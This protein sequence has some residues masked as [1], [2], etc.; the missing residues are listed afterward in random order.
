MKDMLLI[1]YE[2]EVGFKNPIVFTKKIPESTDIYDAIEEF[3]KQ[4]GISVDADTIGEIGDELIDKDYTWHGEHW[5]F[6]VK[7]I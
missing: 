1:V 2:D 3:F 7:Q 4:E 6:S 5:L